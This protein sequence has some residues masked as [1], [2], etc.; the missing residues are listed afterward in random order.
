MLALT[1][2]D[3][4]LTKK[5]DIEKSYFCFFILCYSWRKVDIVYTHKQV[6]YVFNKHL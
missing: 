1:K 4:S 2:I 5:C 6:I 3:L